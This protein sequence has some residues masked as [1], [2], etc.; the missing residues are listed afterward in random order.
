[1]SES[2]FLSRLLGRDMVEDDSR[3]YSSDEEEIGPRGSR[4]R[5]GKPEEGHQPLDHTIERVAETIADLPAAVPRESAV[6]IVR[7]TLEAAGVKLSE[8]D[9]S[10]RA[11]ESRLSSEIELARARQKEVSEKTQEVVHS[12]KE[13]IR[14][15]RESCEN[16][17]AYEEHKISGASTTLK[18]LR[19]VR[20][21][22][23]LPGAEGEE[24]NGPDEQGAQQAHEPFDLERAQIFDTPMARAFD[25]PRYSGGTGEELKEEGHTRSSYSGRRVS[26]S[27]RRR[28]E[29][30][31][32]M[33]ETK[34]EGGAQEKRPVAKEDTRVRKDDVQDNEVNVDETTEHPRSLQRGV[35]ADDDT[36][37]RKTLGR[38]TN[39]DDQT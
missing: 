19:R 10:T 12:L 2:R 5:R 24:D 11:Q 21:F 30:E 25:T 9:A 8:L 33:P 6:L 23:E 13:E 36:G 16:I 14:K 22:F 26:R 37:H 28:R 7:R 3:T 18:E 32:T 39:M 38:D 34:E 29:D 17:M 4:R 31:N 27:N 20:A 15:A 35:R 1:M